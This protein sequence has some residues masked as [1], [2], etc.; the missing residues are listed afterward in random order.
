MK[1]RNVESSDCPCESGRSYAKCCEPVLQGEQL[2]TTAEALMRSRYTAYVREDVDYLRR[3]WHPDNCPA[4]LSFTP[5]Q[6]WLG[7]KVVQCDAGGVDDEAGTVEFVARFKLVDRGHRLHEVSRF[8]RI[9]GQWI[10]MDGELV[11]TEPPREG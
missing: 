9:D 2:P 11:A 1:K 8:Q 6:R 7:L 5:G 3:T 10:Y 4:D